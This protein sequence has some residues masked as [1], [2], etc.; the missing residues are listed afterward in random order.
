MRTRSINRSPRIITN[1]DACLL[2]LE[3]DRPNL[4]E[5]RQAAARI[6]RNGH[7]AGDI[8]KSIRA[9]T[10]KSSPE[11]VS[12]DINEV[13]REVIVLLGAEFRRN[14]VRVETLLSSDL[15]SVVGDRV[16][17]Q[18]VVLNLIMNGIEAMAD[19]T[20]VSVGCRSD[21]RMPNPVVCSLG[22]RIRVRARPG[23]D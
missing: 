13:I 8:I 23:A 9:L 17:L 3:A 10:R 20:P 5:A 11:M 14:G 12:L 19:S 7:R 15:N 22:L 21:L 1:A 16:Q 4:D 6:V 18:Q 2:W